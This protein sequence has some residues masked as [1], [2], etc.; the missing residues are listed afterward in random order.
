MEAKQQYV[1]FFNALK[2]KIHYETEIPALRELLLGNVI[3]TR[4]R[5]EWLEQGIEPQALMSHETPYFTA[6]YPDQLT[7]EMA[8]EYVE[9]VMASTLWI[10]FNIS[11][12]LI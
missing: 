3:T 4:H 1:D 12:I 6:I 8:I 10:H 5:K 9:K 2:K 11:L 7:D